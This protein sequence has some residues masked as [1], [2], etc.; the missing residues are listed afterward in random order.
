MP[1]FGY[2]WSCNR[3]CQKEEEEEEEE[4]CLLVNG[5]EEFSLVLPDFGVV[6]LLQKFGVFVDEPRLAQDV[7]RGVLDLKVEVAPM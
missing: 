2:L 7:G 1:W 4:A 6:D 5:L 3:R